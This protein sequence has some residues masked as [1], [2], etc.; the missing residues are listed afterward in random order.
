MNSLFNLE[1]GNPGLSKA[2]VAAFIIGILAIGGLVYVIFS[3]PTPTEQ[4]Q[5]LLEGA[6]L[7]GSPEFDEY[8]KFII[9]T[10][11]P[12]R[13]Q[14]ATTGLGDVIMN[15]SAVIKNRGDKTLSGLEVSVGMVDTKNQVIKEKKVLFVPKHHPELKPK[16]SI[17]VSVSIAGFS[18]DDDRAN[19]RW[20][21]TA[22]KFG[23]E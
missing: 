13:M 15:L 22:I 2:L 21:V 14:E 20:K 5:D 11:D 8:T 9:I 16:E 7:E 10:N 1:R 12:K 6:L 23:E 17:D 18:A 3:I 4:H 19:A